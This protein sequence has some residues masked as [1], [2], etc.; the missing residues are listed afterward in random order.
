MASISESSASISHLSLDSTPPRSHRRVP[1]PHRIAAAIAAA[2]GVSPCT[3]IVSI[4][5]DSI[6]P[7]RARHL[8]LPDHSYGALGDKLRVGKDGVR[9]MPRRERAV[10]LVRCDR[11]TLPAATRSPS[12]DAARKQLRSGQSDD[13]QP[14]VERRDRAGDSFRHVAARD[15]HVVE[16]AMRLDVLKTSSRRPSPSRQAPRPDR[17][18]GRRSR[19]HPRQFHAGRSRPCRRIPDARRPRRPLERQ[20][21]LWRASPTG[22]RRESRRRCSQT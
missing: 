9:Q 11:Q 4:S 17:E 13:D 18:P 6:E 12:R 20:V 2:S 1:S 8:P 5:S 3:Q 10:R 22:R 21:A 7:S 15:A 14:V 16:R 19:G